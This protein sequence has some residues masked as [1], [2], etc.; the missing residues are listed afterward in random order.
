VKTEDPKRSPAGYTFS[1]SSALAATPAAVWAG[2]NTI[3][4]VNAEF[5]PFLRM[6]CPVPGA[7]LDPAVVPLGRRLF[8]SWLL[9]FGVLPFDW[10]DLR[11][12][13]IEP[14][15]GFLEESSM[16]SQRLWRHE[17]T[18]EPTADGRGCVVT[19]R[20]EFVPRAALRPL[21]PLILRLCRGVFR[22][23]HRRLRQRHGVSG[24]A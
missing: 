22:W 2:A 24:T 13:R 16:L 10:D 7:A 21:G 5:W 6:T 9:L 11:L 20:V 17:R 1:L 23:R 3:E 4:G 8:R 15:Q 18:L 19:D 12:L 14:E